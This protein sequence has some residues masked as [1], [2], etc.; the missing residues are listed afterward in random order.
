M[1]QHAVL[2]HGHG[3]MDCEGSKSVLNEKKREKTQQ[4]TSKWA[5]ARGRWEERGKTAPQKSTT[6][7]RPADVDRRRCRARDQRPQHCCMVARRLRSCSR[8]CDSEHRWFLRMV[9]L[10]RCQQPRAS[11]T[12]NAPRSA[13]A[14]LCPKRAL[15]SAHCLHPWK[16]ARTRCSPSNT[17]EV[18]TSLHA[19]ERILA[20]CLQ[21]D[22]ECHSSALRCTERAWCSACRERSASRQRASERCARRTARRRRN[23]RRCEPS[24]ACARHERSARRTMRARW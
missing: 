6:W 13:L 1:H 24:R 8:R 22:Q 21:R 16:R 17:A 23:S 19:R 4:A 15:R 14:T 10:Q 7:R 9:S 3:T 2:C 18:A 20:R 11:A 5:R 12:M